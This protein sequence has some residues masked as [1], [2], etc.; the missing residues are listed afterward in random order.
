MTIFPKVSVILTSYNHAKYLRESIESVLNQTYKDF[1]LIIW[2]DASTDDSWNIISEYTDERIR[3]FRN[4]TNQFWTYFRKAISEVAQGK[5][6]A[7][8]HSDDIWETDK[9][10]KQVAFLDGH[11]EIGAVFSNAFIIGE[12]SAPFEDASHFSHGIFDQPNRTRHEWLNRF[13]YHG[14]ALCHPSVLIRKMCYEDCGMYRYGFAQANDLDMWV[15]LCLKYDIHVLSEK[16][17]RFRVRAN[18]MNVSG[19]RPEAHIRGEFELFQILDHYRSIKTAEEFI[20]TFPNTNEYFRPEGF[21]I[22]FALGM[23]ALEPGTSNFKKLFGLQLLFEAINDPDR[24]GKVK[25]L[26][27]FGHIDFIALTAKYDVFSVELMPSLSAQVVEKEQANQALRS[28]LHAQNLKMAEITN[29]MAWSAIMRLRRIRLWIAPHDGKRE[30][31]L[32]LVFQSLRVWKNEGFISVFLKIIRKIKRRLSVRNHRAILTT[33]PS[34]SQKDIRA[35]SLLDLQAISKELPVPL[36]YDVIILPEIDWHFRFQRPQQVAR[37]FAK[38]RHRVFYISTTF[39][40]GTK[41]TVRPIEDGVFEVQLPGP[42]SINVYSDSISQQMINTIR[43]AFDSLRYEFDIV[44]AVC[45]VD[46]PFWKSVAFTL[47][48]NFGWNIIYDCID[49]QNRFSNTSEDILQEDD[50]I[51]NSDLVLATSHAMFNELEKIN[52]NCLLVPNAADA[53]RMDFALQNT[54]DARYAQIKQRIQSLFPKAS[55]IIVTYN[56][57]EYTKLCL[58]SIYEKTIYPNFEVI[59]VDNASTDETP[60]FLRFFEEEH[61]NIRVIYNARNEGFAHANNL[62]IAKAHGDYIVLLNNDTVVTRVW[63]SRLISYLDDQRVGLV[64]SVTNGVSN[65][66][67]VEMPF[68]DIITLDV[69]AVKLAK[70]RANILTPVKM[71][72]MYC[73]AGRSEVFK[74]TGPLDEQFGIGMFEDDDYSLRIR[75]AG[76]MIAVAEDVFIH[77]FGRSG[78]KILGDERYLALFEENRKKFEAKWNIKWEQHISGTLAENRR[79]TADL[80]NILDAYPDALGVVIFPPTIGWNINL[81][82]RPHQLARAFAKKGFLVFF[83]TEAEIDGVQGFRQ[84]SASLFLANS[85]WAVFDL[86]EHPVIFTLPYNYEYI[87]Q[88]RQ[89]LIVY[90]VIDDLDVFPGDKTQLQENHDILLKKADVVLVTADRLM[91]QVGRMRPDAIMCPNAVELDHFSKASGLNI[92]SIPLDLASI[93]KTNRPVIGYYGALARWF[94]Y[95]L[96]RQ[97]AQ[98]HPDWDFVLIGPNHDNTLMASNILSIPNIH[99][100]GARDYSQLP[101]YLRYFTVATIPFLVNSITLATSPIKLFEYMA[102]GKPIVTSDMPECRKYPGVFVA[103]DTKEFI[104]HLEQALTLINDPAYL[105]QLY[106]TAQANTWEVRVR[107]I[108]DA[109]EMYQSHKLK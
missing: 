28:Q 62:G 33:I 26:Y 2:D 101:N 84:V 48:D 74:Q 32:S 29:S 107:Q 93:I 63:L 16:L 68:T 45:I 19:D 15:R 30:K 108:V 66:A 94:D 59:V 9:L 72:A 35:K 105:Q 61:E 89:P 60:E 79:F 106:Q 5:Y 55:I 78:F 23:A 76:Y 10:E 57:I 67:H 1:E 37:L 104:D 39:K 56:N 12:N 103:R 13:F 109:L 18:E 91:E 6:V 7:M 41:T 34:Q 85:P 83:C 99:W 42:G 75:Q 70:E 54:W 46:L 90:E 98:K 81:F 44:D 38:E 22:G 31:L 80:Q 82:Q 100:L 53:E 86:V 65:E 8:H 88:L 96:V 14:N 49:Y 27:Q 50:L 24:A 36:L 52:P 47:R 73:V 40:K 20:K 4:E 97:A 71:L 92:Q 69:F 95:G 64:G 21:D 11:P 77:H 3:V 102:A 17:V 87:F 25:E 51:K 43:S 58:K